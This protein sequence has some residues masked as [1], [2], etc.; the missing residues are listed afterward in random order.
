MFIRDDGN[1]EEEAKEEP[2]DAGG[3]RWSNQR[4]LQRVGRTT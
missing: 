1:A 2:S 4:R 3:R